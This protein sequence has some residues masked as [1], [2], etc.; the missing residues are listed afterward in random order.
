VGDLLEGRRIA[1]MADMHY[2]AVAPHNISSPIGTMALAQL[3]A[4]IPNFL[5]L[6]WHAAEVP[7]F[8]DLVKGAKAPLIEKGNI[9]IPDRPGLGIE[10]DDELLTNIVS[11]TNHSSVFHPEGN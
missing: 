6:E 9:K 5:A 2:L 8:D 7:F 11:E 10:L 1:D 3:C 4:A